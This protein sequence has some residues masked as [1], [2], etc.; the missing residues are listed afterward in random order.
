MIASREQLSRY[1]ETQR[2][3]WEK[4]DV[5]ARIEELG[6]ARR[7]ELQ[8]LRSELAPWANRPD[9]FAFFPWVTALAWK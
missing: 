7:E 9:A 1:A 8:A 4:P 3:L 6:L 5:V 2:L